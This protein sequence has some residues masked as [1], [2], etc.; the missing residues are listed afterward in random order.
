MIRIFIADHLK[1]KDYLDYTESIHWWTLMH[2]KI[3]I[4]PIVMFDLKIIFLHFLLIIL[5]TVGSLSICF[6]IIYWQQNR[7]FSF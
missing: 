7:M 3:K 4:L 6:S 5:I 1:V 2:R